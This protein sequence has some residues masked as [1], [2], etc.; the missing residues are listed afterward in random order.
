MQAVDVVGMLCISHPT[1]QIRA[2]LQQAS[3][4]VVAGFDGLLIPHLQYEFEQIKV[5]PL[6]R[7]KLEAC[8][9]GIPEDC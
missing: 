6:A 4:V 2:N 9:T 7:L 5:N 8:K 1:N 3:A